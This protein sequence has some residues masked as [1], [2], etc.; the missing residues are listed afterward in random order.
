MLIIPL[1]EKRSLSKKTATS[2]II[3]QLFTGK[4]SDTS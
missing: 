2:F 4:G 3:P 1:I